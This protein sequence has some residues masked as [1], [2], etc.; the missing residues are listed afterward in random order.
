MKK[1]ILISS[2]LLLTACS[3][4]DSTEDNTVE[5]SNDSTIVQESK[6]V[7]LGEV[8]EENFSMTQSDLEGSYKY[9]D[10][11]KETEVS[12]EENGTLRVKDGSG[13]L[14]YYVNEEYGRVVIDSLVHR[15][16]KMENGYELI[17]ID[18]TG[19]RTN[20]DIQL[21]INE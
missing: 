19:K 11:I 14:R 13:D 9:K 1:I 8:I 12:F 20:N 21:I 18:G 3:N 2:L 10:K 15:V 4:S 6:S 16:N 17:S 5:E 7:S